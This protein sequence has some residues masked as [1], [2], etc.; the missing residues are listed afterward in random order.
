MSNLLPGERIDELQRNDYKIIQNP[1]KF[2][3]WHGCRAA[4]RICQGKSGRKLPGSGCGNGI[5]PLLLSAKTA[6]A[7]FHGAGDSATARILPE[8]VWP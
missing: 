3:L 7:A 8:E 6:G 4:V 5:I 1:Q 2:L